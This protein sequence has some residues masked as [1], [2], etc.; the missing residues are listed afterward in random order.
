MKKK[1]KPQK[2]KAQKEGGK[3]KK[4][5]LLIIIIVVVLGIGGALAFLIF[6]GRLFGK[7]D[8]SASLSA[9]SSISASATVSSSTPASGSASGASVSVASTSGSAAGGSMA[10]SSADMGNAANPSLFFEGEYYFQNLTGGALTEIRLSPAG[11]DSWEDNL[12]GDTTLENGQTWQ[13]PLMLRDLGSTWDLRAKNASGQ[14]WVFKGLN[15]SDNS[16]FV[17]TLNGGTPALRQAA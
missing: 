2:D 4:P 15:F 1:E 5:L 17:L 8:D 10:V 14:E 3:K 7:K 6:T 9:S 16:K 13:Q 11:T 12:L